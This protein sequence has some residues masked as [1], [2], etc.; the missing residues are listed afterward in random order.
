[1]S[2]RD[3]PYGG[4]PQGPYSRGTGGGI[5]LGMPRPTRVVKYL[6]I[7]NFAVFILAALTGQ[8]NSFL[9][10]WG[11]M[12]PEDVLHGQI[13]RLVTYEY[14]HD[15]FSIWHILFNMLGVYFL[16]PPLERSWGPRKFFIFYTVG[17][18][19]GAL[20]YV[21][22]ATA[23]A[24]PP[25][26]MIGASGCVLA[27]LGACALLFPQFQVILFIF[28]VPIRFAAALF[29]GIYVLNLLSRGVNAG[30]DAAHLAG[31]VYGVL[32]PLFGE[33]WLRNLQAVRQYS[34]QQR[35]MH[36]EQDVRAELDRILRKVHEQG[37][38]SLTAAEKRTLADATRRQQGR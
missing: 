9:F 29:C 16:G 21:V 27:V 8:Q 2:W 26:G 17:G 1:M 30:G 22:L 35:H 11:M 32:W 20:F 31:L 5:G 34:K 12:F 14:L 23:G 33:R 19:L 15:P 25:G 7:A 36:S 28:P 3:R 38:N 10:K 24:L 4:E 13:W 37:V 18:V 6:L